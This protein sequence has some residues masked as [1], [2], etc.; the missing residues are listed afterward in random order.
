MKAPWKYRKV[1]AR[2]YDRLHFSYRERARGYFSPAS[3]YGQC[4][5]G[6]WYRRGVAALRDIFRGPSHWTREKKCSCLEPR[7]DIVDCLVGVR[8]G[9]GHLSW[10]VGKHYVGMCPFKNKW[11]LRSRVKSWTGRNGR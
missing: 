3:Y 11:K 9:R 7:K 4:L 2:E 8:N 10:L 5:G 6:N 1:S